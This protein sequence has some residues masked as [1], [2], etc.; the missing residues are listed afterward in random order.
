[1]NRFFNFLVNLGESE[2]RSK[3]EIIMRLYG[4]HMDST[5]MSSQAKPIDPAK[6]LKKMTAFSSLLYWFN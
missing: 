5:Q 3:E 4:G 1:M 6:N 2:F